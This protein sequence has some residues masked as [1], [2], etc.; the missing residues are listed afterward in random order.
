MSPLGPERGSR[1]PDITRL[2]GP[3]AGRQPTCAG[4]SG[5][6]RT[7]EARVPAAPSA[8]LMG[9]PAAHVPPRGQPAPGVESCPGALRPP[10][11]AALGLPAPRS[12]LAHRAPLGQ[13]APGSDAAFLV[14]ELLHVLGN[15]LRP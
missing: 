5:E 11:P 2:E 12:V 14:L 13:E 8:D 6:A 9:D 3:C 4:A 7:R 15:A 1:F 10:G